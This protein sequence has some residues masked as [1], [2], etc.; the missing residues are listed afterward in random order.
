MKGSIRLR[1]GR[2]IGGNH[3]CFIVAEVGNNHQGSL[4]MALDMI[5]EAARCGVDAIKFQKRHNESL[6]TIEGRNAPYNGK[7]SFGRTYGEHREALE[8]TIEEM[9][10]AKA[11]AEELGLIFFASTWDAVSLTQMETLG[12]ELLKFSSADLVSLPLLRQAGATGIPIILSTGMS[13]YPEIDM[14]VSLL[15]RFHDN[16]VV[17]HCNSSYPCPE[18]QIGLP[19]IERLRERYG[20]PV[21]YSGHEQGLGPSV[22]AAALGACVLERHFTLDRTLPGTDHK[23]SLD[24]EGLAQLVTMVREVEKACCVKEKQVFPSE[25]SSAKKLRKSIVFARDLPAGHVLTK[26][27]IMVKCPGTGLSPIHWDGIIGSTLLTKARFEE[28]ISWDM[29]VPAGGPLFGLESA[30]GGE[31]R[32]RRRAARRAESAGDGLK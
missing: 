17:L 3:P 25:V 6:L 8:L 24:P 30:S 26:A 7:N 27:D 15:R 9:A 13:D 1:S 32:P 14:A 5:R 22:A 12:V 31:E 21:G 28:Q 11:L 19:V 16:L 29:I 10:L 18:E 4:D 23:V 2:V 20:Q